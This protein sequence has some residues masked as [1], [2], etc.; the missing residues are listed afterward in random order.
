M[1]LSNFG[2]LTVVEDEVYL[3][4]SLICECFRDSSNRRILERDKLL[5]R[6]DVIST[7]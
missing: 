3:K 1:Q 7:T 2:F 6:F 4:R 5:R